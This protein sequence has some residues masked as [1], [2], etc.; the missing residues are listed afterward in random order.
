MILGLI[1]RQAVVRLVLFMVILFGGYVYF[2]I[3]PANRLGC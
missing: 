3:C 1:N 2:S